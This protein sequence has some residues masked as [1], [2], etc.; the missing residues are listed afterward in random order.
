M[1]TL[2]LACRTTGLP[3][4]Q[5]QILG[6]A[7]TVEVADDPTERARG[8]MY[9]KELAADAGMLFVYAEEG[10]RAF[11][12]KNTSLPLSIAYIAADGTIVSIAEMTPFSTISVPSEGAALYALEV[13]RGW[14]DSHGVTAGGS[15]SGLPGAAPE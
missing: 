13:N 12:M 14:Y 7:V 6:H 9:R 10:A 3:T 2:L 8:L 4:A 1:W 11:W 15:V 5:L